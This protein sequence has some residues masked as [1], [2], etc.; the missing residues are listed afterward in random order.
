LLCSGKVTGWRRENSPILYRGEETGVKK[1]I[2]ILYEERKEREWGSKF[3]RAQ[4]W[5]GQP[6]EVLFPHGVRRAGS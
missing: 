3:P 2:D 6:E 1:H 5:R 4:K